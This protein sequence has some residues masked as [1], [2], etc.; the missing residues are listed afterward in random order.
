MKKFRIK[1]YVDL[2]RT[3]EVEADNEEDALN[4]IYG[5]RT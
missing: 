4:L 1:E 2:I 3:Y 5:R